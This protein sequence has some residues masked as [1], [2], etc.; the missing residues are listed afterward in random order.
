MLDDAELARRSIRG[1]GEMVAA[2]GCCAGGAQTEI[3]RR[4][5]LGARIDAAENP[6][7]D[8]AIVP[9]GATPPA[10]DALLPHCLWT[11]AAHVTGR[12]EDPRIATPCMGV[13]LDAAAFDGEDAPDVEEPSLAVVGD[14]NDRAY[15]AVG[16]FAPLVRRRSRPRERAAGQR[17]VRLRRA[18]DRG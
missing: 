12:V 3:R 2:L 16:A 7:F 8:A 18:D 6:W 14:V 1:F 9:A 11:I 15:G 17:D 13:A 10:D 4:D 5:A